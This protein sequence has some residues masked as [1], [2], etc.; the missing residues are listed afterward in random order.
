MR[1]PGS[2]ALLERALLASA[3]AHGLA[4]TFDGT[5]STSWES[6]TFS[7]ARHVLRASA[8]TGAIESWLEELPEADLPIRGHLV[9]D[10]AITAAARD[11]NA[12]RFTIAVL[13]VVC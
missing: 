9:A 4:V 1:G 13:T 3:K 10:L 2:T 5:Q 11:R 7:G 12:H 6:A 8:T